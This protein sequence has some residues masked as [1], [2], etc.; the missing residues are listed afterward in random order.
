MNAIEIADGIYRI[1]SNIDNGDLFEGMW[2][3]PDGVSLN[4][5]VVKGEKTAIIDLVDDWDTAPADVKKQLSEISVDP[6]EVDYIVLN[7]LEPDHTGWLKGFL[8]DNEDVIIITTPKGEKMIRSFFNYEGPVQAVADG[9]VLDLGGGKE[10]TFYHAPF[11]HWPETMVTFHKES[12]ILFSCDAFGSYGKLGDAVFD[13]QI[14]DEEHKF[15]DEE[16]L[17]YYANI[18]AGFSL[19]VQKAITKLS[20]LDIKMIAPSHGLIWRENPSVIIDRYIK[21]AGYMKGPA[22]P[23]ITIIWGSMYGNT[24]KVLTSVI[25]GIR[26]EGVPVHVHNVPA[27]HIS[28]AL[29]S[30]WK[31]RGLIFGMPTYEN[32]MFPPMATLID[33]FGLKHV[34]HKKVFRFGSYG[35]GG[36][37]Q[38]DFNDRIAKLKWECLDP[39]EWEGMATENEQ[40]I[41]YEQGKK[42]AQWV[43]EDA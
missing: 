39:L 29:T 10:L 23:E 19:S 28:Y 21:F 26:S 12:G 6:R 17:R 34:W 33:M 8:S 15:Y 9:D 31:S 20:A 41:A 35:W 30:A 11:V 38:K 32:K 13:D 7:H 18:V 36:G 43:K 22:E 37:A 16:S 42:L 14:S 27:D 5:Y 3:I 4:S 40:K 25:E 1:G 2:P 24:K